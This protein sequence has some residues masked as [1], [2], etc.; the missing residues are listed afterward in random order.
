[1][2]SVDDDFD[3]LVVGLSCRSSVGDGDD[4]DGLLETAGSGGTEDERLKD[5]TVEGGSEL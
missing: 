2:R 5:F 1:L 4:E 3:D